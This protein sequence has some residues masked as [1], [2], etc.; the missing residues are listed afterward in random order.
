MR[1]SASSNSNKMRAFDRRGLIAGSLSALLATAAR[2]KPEWPER[3]V[4]IV[5]GF[6]AGGPTDLVARIVADALTGALAQRVLVESKP[7]ASGTT[8]AAQVARAAPD[9]YTLLAVPAGHVFAAATFKSLPYRSVEDFTPI[10]ML[11]EY[12]YLLV[13]YADHPVHTVADLVAL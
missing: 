4:T 3:P 13:T 8:A 11:T 2:A 6:P 7:G 5:H 9:G 10:S 12:P 1:S